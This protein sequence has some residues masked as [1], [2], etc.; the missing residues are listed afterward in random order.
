MWTRAELKDNAKKFFKYN[1]WKMV[2]V[3]LVLGFAGG[4]SGG[5]GA[6]VSF[7]R[8]YTYSLDDLSTPEFMGFLVGFFSVFMIAMVIGMAVAVFLLY[9]LHVGAQR[10]FVV[11]HYQKAEP[12]ELG[13]AFS[14]GYMNVV[15]TMF[16]RGLFTFLWTL[17]LSFPVLSKVTNTA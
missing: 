16:L 10:F 12:G 6:R 7:T 15:K 11:S 8:T 3:S 13:Y 14:N 5:G 4:S 1:Y 2:L 17:L 9:P